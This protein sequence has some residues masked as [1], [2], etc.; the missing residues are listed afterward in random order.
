MKRRL[1]SDDPRDPQAFQEGLDR[2]YTRI[3]R[4]YDIG[5]K[6]FPVW[7]TWLR[8]VLP[9][10]TGR[11]VL[12]V[13]FG[14][15]YL[16]THYAGQFEVHGIDLNAR[17]L[18]VAKRNLRKAELSARLQQGTVENLPYEKG[19]FDTV[20]N[21]MAFSGYPDA[22]KAMSEMRRVLKPR[23]RLVLVDISYPSDR[24]WVGMR[25]TRFWQRAGDIIRDIDGVLVRHGFEYEDMEIGGFGSVHL[26]ICDRD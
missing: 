11:R 5:I 24:N 18:S 4:L 1:Y 20:V 9:H 2:V 14:T 25:L 13:S 10:I 3:A 8:Q 7:K 16:M 21:T 22:N 19:C 17:M 12:E 23:G 26:Y 15:G 6:V